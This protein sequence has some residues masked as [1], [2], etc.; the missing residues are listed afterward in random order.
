MTDKK[1]TVYDPEFWTSVYMQGRALAIVS[2]VQYEDS[3]REEVR[4]KT[5]GW[6]T[7]PQALKGIVSDKPYKVH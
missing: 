3:V 1:H 6:G 5:K 7:I 4:N 2:G